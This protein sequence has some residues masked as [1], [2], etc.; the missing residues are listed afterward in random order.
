[1][2]EL[3]ANAVTA[4]ESPDWWLP[5]RFWLYSDGKQVM[6]LVW[7]ANPNPPVLMQPDDMTEDGRG[8]MLVDALSTRWDWYAAPDMIEG[9]VTWSLI[10]Q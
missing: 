6:V 9:K 5:V 7:D 3:I 8:L 1:M 10:S 2:S 4:S